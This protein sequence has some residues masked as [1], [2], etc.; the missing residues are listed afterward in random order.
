MNAMFI[1]KTGIK[2][3]IENAKDFTQL[4]HILNLQLLE[5]ET[6]DHVVRPSWSTPGVQDRSRTLKL[7]DVS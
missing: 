1:T 7:Q 2:I 4:K 6:Q 3:T 5:S